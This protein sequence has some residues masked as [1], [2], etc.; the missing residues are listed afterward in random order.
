[1]KSQRDREYEMVGLSMLGEMW[2]RTIEVLKKSN[3]AFEAIHNCQARMDY[4]GNGAEPWI[5]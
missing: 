3:H 4:E 5:S 2:E 1:M